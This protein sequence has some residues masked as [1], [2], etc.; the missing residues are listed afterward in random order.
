MLSFRVSSNSMNCNRG[1]NLPTR[2]CLVVFSVHW[3][4]CSVTWSCFFHFFNLQLF[5]IW[6]CCLYLQHVS[7]F[8]FDVCISWV[9]FCICR[10][11]FLYLLRVFSESAAC[12]FCFCN[13]FFLCILLVLFVFGCSVICCASD[14]HCQI[15][16]D[17]FFI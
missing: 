7:V 8:G 12:F 5:C 11:C 16:E 2:V 10:M 3:K 13:M 14:M 15:G 9:V 4:L 6:L 1:N 17:V